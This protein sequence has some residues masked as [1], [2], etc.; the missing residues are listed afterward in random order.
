EL[1][2]QPENN[3]RERLRQ[4][5]FE[6]RN[7]G[8]RKRSQLDVSNSFVP[9][10]KWVLSWWSFQ[11][12]SL[13]NAADA[14]TLGQRFTLLVI[15]VVYRGCGI[16]VAWKIVAATGKG[17]WKPHWLKLFE[18]LEGGIPSDW[19]IIVTTDR[20][21]YAKWLYEEICRLGWHP[22]MRINQQGHYRPVGQPSFRP[23]NHLIPEVGQGWT[24]LVSCFSTNT[25]E[26][27]LLA[28]WDEGYS[29]PWLI[30]TDLAE[31][32]AEICWYG[33]RSWIEC[34]FK[35]IKRGGFQ[36]HLTKMTDPQRA[37]RLW[38]AIAVATLWLVSV[39]G[40]A[41]AQLSASSLPSLTATGENPH[42]QQTPLSEK[43]DTQPHKPPSNRLLSCFRRG[44]L[45][46]LA[47]ALKGMAL[48]MGE[49]FPDFFPVPAP[50]P[51]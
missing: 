12:K 49:F 41:D 18:H 20:G 9:L 5:Y 27:T 31:Q 7:F 2:G 14:S 33:L 34:L 6:G 26:C 8:G 36:W 23:G 10:L 38:L 37:E 48:P 25:L 21:L 13:V 32:Q 47:T 16:P 15:S 40:K 24:G 11:E 46:I 44:F 43:L 1:L 51:G 22:F 35:D 50:A 30:V 3:I 39:G 29:D 42:L 45:I 28:R 19:F 17:S 4:W